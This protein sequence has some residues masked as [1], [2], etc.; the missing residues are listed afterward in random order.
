MRASTARSRRHELVYA[1]AAIRRGR[2]NLRKSRPAFVLAFSLL[3]RVIEGDA[4]AARSRRDAVINLRERHVLF[5]FH[6]LRLQ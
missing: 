2:P 3:V 4:A 5:V 1:T 6:H